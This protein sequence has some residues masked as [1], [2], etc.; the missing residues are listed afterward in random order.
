MRLA[1]LFDLDENFILNDNFCML[2]CSLTPLR[3]RDRVK[4]RCN[5]GSSALAGNLY[6]ALASVCWSDSCGDGCFYYYYHNIHHVYCN[7]YCQSHTGPNGSRHATGADELRYYQPRLWGEWLHDYQRPNES[8]E[9]L[10][11]QV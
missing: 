2:G 5:Q 1:L 8:C 4:A 10:W 11:V 6:L 3:M 7:T 9:Y